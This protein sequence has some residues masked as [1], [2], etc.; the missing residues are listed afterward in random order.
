MTA[1]SPTVLGE[2]AT[3]SVGPRDD[4][5]GSATRATRHVRRPHGV[6]VA[7]RYLDPTDAWVPLVLPSA[8]GRLVSAA[9]LVHLV[10]SEATARGVRSIGTA[11]ELAHPLTHDLLGALQ[12]HLGTDL[13][14]V[15]TRCAGSSV[16]VTARLLA[17]RLAHAAPDVV[18]ARGSDCDDRWPTTVLAR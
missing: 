1:R 16:M 17:P 12:R 14:A 9:Q 3:T 10:V 4:E 5:P 7:F 11:L 13:E 15:D 6:S 18:T 8:D 2:R